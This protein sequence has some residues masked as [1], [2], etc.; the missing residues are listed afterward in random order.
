[1]LFFERDSKPGNPSAFWYPSFKLFHYKKKPRHCGVHAPACG[2]MEEGP[3]GCTVSVR[4]RGVGWGHAESILGLMES[5][6]LPLMSQQ[7]LSLIS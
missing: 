7:S 5:F 4:L 6:Y 2:L 3:H 1:M